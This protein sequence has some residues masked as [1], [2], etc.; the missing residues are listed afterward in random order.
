MVDSLKELFLTPVKNNKQ[1]VII[2]VV[3]MI[4]IFMP[5]QFP[6]DWELN[7]VGFWSNITN[8]YIH[9][10]FVYPP[11]GLI[12]MIPYQIMHAEGARFLSVLVIGWLVMQEK[13]SLSKFFA[14]VLSPYFVVTM[15]KSSID[16]LVFVFPLLLWKWV[17]NT[18]WQ[19]VGWGFAL[20]ILLLKPQGGLLVCLYLLWVS[21]KRY[22]ELIYPLI[23][24]VL[25][26]IPVSL[27]GSPPLSIQWL[28]NIT[29]P[30]N[31]NQYYWSNNNVSLMDKYTFIGAVFILILLI[32]VVLILKQLKKLE[33]ANNHTLAALLFGSI[34]LSPYASQQSVSSAMAFIPSWNA[35]FIQ[36]IGLLL[37]F[38]TNTFRENVPIWILLF[39]FGALISSLPQK[40]P[41]PT[42]LPNK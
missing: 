20:S 31:Q 6:T 33:W 21:R 18:K 16:I 19:I 36:I 8:T 28:V 34:F 40:Q 35:V 42:Y 30:S 26:V 4:Y 5:Q 37:A 24:V 29:H 39:A 2:L 3:G 32:M 7:T 11:W 13:W 25:V 14:I 41:Y 12:L 38:S 17:D 10:N 27:I 23:I 1:K 15:S 9:S 22:K